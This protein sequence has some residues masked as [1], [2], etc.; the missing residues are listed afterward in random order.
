LLNF[1]SI[2]HIRGRR[3]TVVESVV[4]KVEVKRFEVLIVVRAA[5]LKHTELVPTNHGSVSFHP[6]Q[7]KLAKVIC[8]H[9]DV[10]ID[11]IKESDCCTFLKK[12]F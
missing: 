8:R 9:R 6:G 4:I 11:D 10:W 12:G 2:K 7:V 5:T 3:D 1:T